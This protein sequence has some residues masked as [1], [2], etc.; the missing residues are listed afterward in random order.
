VAERNI[1]PSTVECGWMRGNLLKK[2]VEFKA[3][4]LLYVM[5]YD[6]IEEVDIFHRNFV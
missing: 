2:L 1:A 5:V 4:A 6:L 3:A